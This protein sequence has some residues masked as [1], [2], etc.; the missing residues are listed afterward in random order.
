MTIESIRLYIYVF[1]RNGKIYI[2]FGLMTKVHVPTGNS[3]MESDN[4]KPEQ[5]YNDFRQTY[6]GVFE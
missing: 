6:G 4:T 3:K 5:K 2:L 1:N